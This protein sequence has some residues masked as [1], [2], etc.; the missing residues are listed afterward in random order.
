MIACRYACRPLAAAWLAMGLLASGPALAQ[1]QEE[2]R[3]ICQNLDMQR[4]MLARLSGYNRVEAEIITEDTCVQI[5]LPVDPVH[6]AADPRPEASHS[7]FVL[8]AR[9]SPDGRTIASAGGD[10]TV[11]IWDAETGMPVRAIMVAPENPFGNPNRTGV[12]RSVR[13]VGDGTR[14]AVASDVN[15]VRLLDLASGT[16]AAVGGLHHLQP[17][18]G[19]VGYRNGQETA[20][21]RSVQGSAIRST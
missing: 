18:P 17:A 16:I 14:I 5:D 7:M 12:A 8:D 10:G 20:L 15:P 3:Q 1:T 6:V 11:R 4:A 13:F 21:F 9:F 2:W 19:P